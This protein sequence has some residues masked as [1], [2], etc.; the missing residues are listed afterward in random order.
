MAKRVVIN[1]ILDLYDENERLR[2]ELV[3]YKENHIIACAKID[4]DNEKAKIFKDLEAKAKGC[5][6][7]KVFY[8]YPLDYS[9]IEVK[10]DDGEINFLTFEQWIKSL[11]NESKILNS[12][13]RYLLDSLTLKEIF[14]YFKPALEDYFNK[15]VN[16]KKMEILRAKKEEKQ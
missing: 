1:E 7:E 14:E 13:Y 16:D 9:N 2:N 12:N 3:R 5:L 4:E 11:K 8:Y 10:E 6:L 15:R